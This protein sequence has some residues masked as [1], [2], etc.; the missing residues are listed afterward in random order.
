MPG[1]TTAL[2]T[3]RDSGFNGLTNLFL[4][5]D[6]TLTTDFVTYT[7]DAMSSGVDYYLWYHYKE[8]AASTGAI[9][10][11]FNTT[12]S[13]P[14]RGSSKYQGDD[15]L[16]VSGNDVANILFAAVSGRMNVVYDDIQI[17]EDELSSHLP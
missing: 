7:T 8:G 1:S 11:W 17:S 12:D 5:T 9:E 16:T 14:A 4:A 15:T 2:F 13:R 6:G 10:V 3:P